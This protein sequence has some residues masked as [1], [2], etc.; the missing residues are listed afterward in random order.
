MLIRRD[1]PKADIPMDELV[2]LIQ[3]SADRAG[4]SELQLQG[5]TD[6]HLR[7]TLNRFGINYNP[8]VNLGLGRSYA[9]S[10]RPDSLFGHVV[11]DYKAPGVLATPG[12]FAAAK[13]QVTADY[14]VPICTRQ[15]TLDLEE[16]A[17]W[18]GVLLDGRQ[19]AFATFDGIETW[20]W[21]PARPVSRS[22]VLTLI[23]FYRALHRKP[24]NPYLLA[25]DFGRD[26]ELAV[27]CIRTLARYLTHPLARTRMLFREWRRMFEQVSTYELDQIPALAAW[28]RRWN[29]PWQDD[30]SLLLYCLHTYYAIIVKLLTVELVTV[31]QQF[32]MESFFEKL[33]H[34]EEALDFKASFERLESGEVYRDLRILNFLEGD[35]FSWYL[36]HFDDEM[37]AALRQ[38]VDVF[39]TYE[40]ATPKLDPRRCQD[41]LKVFYCQ[42]IDG[43][44]R[45]DLGEYYTPDWLAELVLDRVAYTGQRGRTLMDPACG[46][47][48]FLVTAIR[49]RLA[50]ATARGEAANDV[51]DDV[52]RHILGFDLNPL[53]VISSR[54]NVLLALTGLL[55]EYG[56]DIEIPIY[57]ADSINV[58]VSKNVDGV[59]CLVFCLNTELGEREIALPISLVRSRVMAPLLHVIER[60]VQEHRTC[61]DFLAAIR[62]D[63]HLAQHIGDDEE[64]MLR[65][66]YEVIL[67]L[68]A[69]D[70]DEIWCRIVKNHFATQSLP[71]VDFIVGNPP[72]VRWSRLPRRYRERCKVFCSYYGLVSGRGYAGGIESD[73]AT[74]VTYSAVD[75]WLSP[76]GVI[77]FLITATVF[78]N[79][80]ARGFRRF[81]LPDGTPLHPVGIDDLV[82]LLPFPDATNETALLVLRKGRQGEDAEGVYPAGG[83]AWR[84]W[85]RTAGH[86]RIDPR[87]TLAGVRSITEEVPL[88]ATPIADR[89][90]PLYTGNEDDTRRIRAFRGRSNYELSAHKGTTT[91]ASRVYWVKVLARDRA[92]GRVRIRSLAE[93]ELPRARTTGIRATQGFWIEDDFVYP[94]MRGRDLGRYCCATDDW[95][96]LVPNQHYTDMEDEEEF[97]RRFPLAYR[98]FAR[99]RTVL[100]RRST[101]RRYLRDKPFYAIYDVGEYTFSPYKV[102]W[103]EQ[104]NPKAFRASVIGSLPRA[105]SRRRLIVPD[106]K[107]Y[108]LSLH[109]AREAHYVCGVLNSRHLRR[110]LGGFL[111]GKQIGTS[112]FRYVR[113]PE[114]DA[115]NPRHNEISELSAD[116]HTRRGRSR[117]T[118]DLPAPE[119]RRLDALTENI[120]E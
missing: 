2:R 10:G 63:Q 82:P 57:L 44:I 79:D 16:S 86:G 85:Q 77:G 94:L 13:R 27:S 50:T 53:A 80:S 35:F 61:D 68:E 84:A 38:V 55:G 112:I 25:D 113:V 48:T 75:N 104:Q 109:D 97:R 118:Q 41:L 12:G 107:L 108:M 49:R 7:A 89:G 116:A 28:A 114:Y 103:M 3:E 76:G 14:L 52:F 4:D 37:E 70:W 43:Q 24:L 91:D 19:I 83:V 36:L 100:T 62:A 1:D 15:G 34:T 40:P 69:Q 60:D 95:H 67:D 6:A 87:L 51:L 111:V 101:Y 81:E 30:P 78:K 33:A 115:E 11:L 54:A 45:H 119:Q 26:T 46:S 117:D 71:S 47:G 73:I 120:F 110:I 96:V 90:S 93:E 98:Y 72:W 58:P 66:F 9:T 21:T 74:V 102:V 5:E 56:R 23:Q 42:V 32:A 18:V 17:K 64:V 99:S 65:R 106:H 88:V 31:S 22:T 92:A 20:T 29:L 39:R 59:D 8:Q 105:V